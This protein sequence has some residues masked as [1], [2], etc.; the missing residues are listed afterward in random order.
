M[1]NVPYVK[2]QVDNASGY[3]PVIL[4]TPIDGEVQNKNQKQVSF[5]FYFAQKRCLHPIPSIHLK[6]LSMYIQKHLGQAVAAW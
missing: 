6:L 1:E 5:N 4:R 3:K 2:G